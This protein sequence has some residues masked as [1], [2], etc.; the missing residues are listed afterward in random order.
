MESDNFLTKQRF[1][2]MVEQ[3]VRTHDLT[4]M[5]AII[6]LAETHNIEL[7]DMK[8]YISSVIKEKIESEAQNLN[9]L[10][11]HNKLQF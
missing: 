5:D 11:K 1:S 4:Y 10:P 2:K 6:Y 8:R 3:T 9:F 7:E